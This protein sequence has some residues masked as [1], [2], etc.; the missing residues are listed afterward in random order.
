MATPTVQVLLD[1]GTGTFPINITRWCLLTAGFTLSRGRQD[2]QSAVSAGEL[3]LTLN[4]ADGR[5]T[6]G[7][8]ILGSPSPIKVDQ[9]IRLTETINGTTFIRFT[10]YVK[11]WPVTWPATVATW[12]TVQLVA[13][14]AQ[15]RAERR[16]L[17]SITDEEVGLATPAAYYKC[18]E[19]AGA[20][21][22]GDSSGNQMP[23]LLAAG[24]GNAVVFGNG[25]ADFTA[26]QYLHAAVTAAPSPLGLLLTRSGLPAT[27]EAVFTGFAC[28]I[29][30]ETSGKLSAYRAGS[31][32]AQTA[33]SICDGLPHPVGLFGYGNP[34]QFTVDGS[35]VAT[36]GTLGISLTFPQ[37]LRFGGGGIVASTGLTGQISHI[38]LGAVPGLAQVESGTARLTRIA[39]YAGVPL[40]TLDT[41][42]TN[43]AVSDTSGRSAWESIQEVADAEM[44]VAFIDGSGNLRFYNRNR[45]IS[46]TTPDLTLAAT[47]LAADVTASIDDQQ[48]V[49]YFEVTS[50]ATQVTQVVRDTASENAHG[51]YPQS[52]AYLVQTDQEVLDRGNWVIFTHQEPGARYGTLKINL[53]KMDP[54]LATAVLTA[55]DM[56]AWLRI[57]SMPA[58]NIGGTSAD[59]VVEGYSEEGNEDTWQLVLNVSDK[60]TVYPTPWILGHAVY[61]VLGSTT[62]LYV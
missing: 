62:R 2:W 45:V 42:L 34:G 4:N 13:T 26:G 35:T 37:D 41:S 60:A 58:Q 7:S 48:I 22:A 47:F 5:F 18:D 1:D 46:K 57:V 53:Y 25:G 61:S 15:A 8:T 54:V 56:G 36:W 33:T 21:G 14:D 10:G 31:L 50:E 28:E 9:R 3:T 17:G 24:A 30:V 38:A 52:K 16:V 20:L 6:V 59:L 39:G 11:Q 55:I 23:S 12:A 40:G 49:N 44:G 43:V 19:P 51:R 27:P 29:V 32:A